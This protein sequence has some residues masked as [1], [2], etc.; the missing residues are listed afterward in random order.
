[1]S[2]KPESGGVVSRVFS[3]LTA[4]EPTNKPKPKPAAAYSTAPTETAAATSAP[5]GPNRGDI[6]QQV[7]LKSARSVAKIKMVNLGA[8]KTGFSKLWSTIRDKLMDSTEQAIKNQLGPGDKVVKTGDGEYLVTFAEADQGEAQRTTDT[9]LRKVR[10]QIDASGEGSEDAWV[11][12]A[13]VE[14]PKRP[15]AP[16]PTSET[17]PD[18][19]AEFGQSQTKAE[20]QA[21]FGQSQTKAEKQAEFGQSQTKAEKQ[22]DYGQSQTKAE[23]QASFGQSQTKAEKRAE[24]GQ[25]KTKAE[26]QADF[27][28]SQTK[29]EKQADYGQ[30]QT[31]S[32]KQADFG[33]SQTKAGKQAEFERSQTRA[34]KEVDFGRTETRVD[35]T[36]E[37]G[38]TETR[39]E[40]DIRFTK[41]GDDASLLD[42]VDR[43]LESEIEKVAKSESVADI[44]L[45]RKLRVVFRPAWNPKVGAVSAFVCTPERSGREG[46]LVGEAAM[47]AG[48]D[49]DGI[50]LSDMHILRVAIESVATLVA[51]RTPALIVASIRYQSLAGKH[52]TRVL[53][54][55]RAIPRELKQYMIVDLVGIPT[56]SS[57]SIIGANIQSFIQ[58]CRSVTG[59]TNLQRPLFASFT[60]LNLSF[61]GIDL[62]A[63]NQSAREAAPAQFENFC[64]KAKASRFDTYIWGVDD[65]A[66]FKMA[67]KA[68]FGL[69][70]G[71]PVGAP[72]ES[73]TGA[74]KVQPKL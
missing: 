52:K 31:K 19:Q 62:T 32:E 18:K 7:G 40:K 5:A 22:A 8:A 41:P 48:A 25:S 58:F 54:A 33:Q 23:Q 63:L 10:G 67:V 1:M 69:I 47:P 29:A 53:E 45:Q 26:Q 3:F 65:P 4:D 15:D 61:V 59:R 27:G 28:Q 74:F 57:K 37:V 2:K 71:L 6:A 17:I 11:R 39:P 72:I 70:N 14:L 51:R 44:L 46:A 66:A 60:E 55:L 49:E 43:K 68:G 38:R 36:I 42:L 30:S 64:Q 16:V 9:I 20:Q 56:D 50:M 12:G 21:N 35:K 24:F 13:A 34:E 73:P